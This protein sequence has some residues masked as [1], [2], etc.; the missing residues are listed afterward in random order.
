[1]VERA[2]RNRR[3]WL[4]GALGP[5]VVPFKTW[6]AVDRNPFFV[7]TRRRPALRNSWIGCANRAI[8]AVRA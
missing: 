8:P 6:D 3:A 2:L 5:N 4:L 7:A 1:M